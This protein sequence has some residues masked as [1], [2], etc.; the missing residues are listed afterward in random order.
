MNHPPQ[1]EQEITEKD[2]Y[3]IIK[4][5]DVRISLEQGIKSCL[6]LAKSYHSQQLSKALAESSGKL[7]TDEQVKRK[8]LKRHGYDENASLDDFRY[9]KNGN[10]NELKREIELVKWM[11]DKAAEVIA[12]LKEQ[13]TKENK[14]GTYWM[15]EHDKIVELN[16]RIISEKDKLLADTDEEIRKLKDTNFNGFLCGQEALG[17]NPP[18]HYCTCSKQYQSTAR[19]ICDGKCK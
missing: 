3:D 18:T 12:I 5:I 7:P 6:N 16:S 11:R 15:K 1:E 10:G 17:E 4:E 14:S 13:V 2:F 8:V 9:D 19:V